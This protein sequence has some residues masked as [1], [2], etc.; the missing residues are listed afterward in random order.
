[1]L[2]PRRG[3][4]CLECRPVSDHSFLPLRRERREGDPLALRV[5]ESGEDNPRG[6]Y[7][8]YWAQSAR[9]LRQNLALEYAI[10]QANELSI[11]IKLFPCNPTLLINRSIRKAARAI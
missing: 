5:T 1:M 6:E 10:A 7:I 3:A 9:R 4:N 11:G 2:N 8:L